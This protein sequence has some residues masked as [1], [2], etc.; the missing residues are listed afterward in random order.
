VS[1][2]KGKRPTTG[3]GGAKGGKGG[4]SRLGGLSGGR[5]E[6]RRLGLVIFGVVFIVLF[7][8]V[9]IAE[10]LGD[11]SIPSGSIAVV[12]EIPDGAEAPF[13][14]PFED[15]KGNTVTQDLSDVTQAEYDCAFEQVVASAGL[16]KTPK[17][18]E[19][20]FDE[21]K[22]TTVGS[23]LETIWIQGLAAE[24]GIEVTEKE[25]EE[26]LNKLKKQNFKTEAEFQSFLK[27]SH[28]TPQDVNERVKIQILST[29]I[30]EQLGEGAG[31]P[32]KGEIEEYYEEAKGTQFT[33]P[34]TV[35]ARILIAKTEKDAAAAMAALVK[36]NSPGSWKKVIKKYS[37]T[38]SPNGGL[39]PG[40]TEEQYAGEVGEALFSAPIGKVEGPV[41]YAT[42]G[43]VVFEVQKKNP[44]KVQPL[45]EA[46][47][48]IKAQLQQQSQ[49][50]VFGTFVSDFQS[51]WRSR[52]FCSGDYTVEKCANFK[53]D[54]RPAEADPACFEAS[55]KAEPEACPAPVS[56]TK[57]ALPG[58]VSLLTPKGEQLAQRPQ[59]AGLEASPEGLP[60]F[61]GLPPGVTPEGAPP[62]GAPPTAP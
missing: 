11:P 47:A 25:V 36:D 54:G 15:C 2:S 21:L 3:R 29:K 6:A 33:T 4:A 12:E 60:S 58:T 10:G 16:K 42:S 24:E 45:G 41:K 13:D 52:T 51:L 22:E 8:A 26:E 30:Q 43:F 5:E 62:E 61:E 46:E 27:T 31:E 18:G 55:P 20:Q 40:V 17:P 23:I 28:Y 53:S 48:Q 57:P 38:P 1:P 44:E 35:D 7:V 50:A 39:Q 59:P 34:P 19:K 56:Q 9:A 14:K 37:E 49:E 32:S